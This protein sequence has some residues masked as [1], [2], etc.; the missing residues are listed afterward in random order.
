MRPVI[1]PGFRVFRRNPHQLQFGTS[2]DD[3]VVVGDRP[4]LVALLRLLD[5]TRDLATVACLAHDRIDALADDPESLLA[6]LAHEGIVVDGSSND[7]VEPALEAEARSLVAQRLAPAEITDRFVRRSQSCVEVRADPPVEPIVTAMTDCL[8]ESG[9]R[10]TRVADTLATVTLVVGSGPSDRAIFTRLRRDNMPHLVV[11][12]DGPRVVIGPF[13]YPGLTPCTQCLD[14]WRHGWDP[15]W[16]AVTPQLDAPLADA[17]GD[18]GHSTAAPTRFA[19]AAVVTHE[20]T[21]FCDE[22][23][24]Q[25]SARTITIGPDLH[26]RAERATA[27]H[28][29]C[30]CRAGRAPV[31]GLADPTQ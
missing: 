11:V 30:Q 17:C 8:R 6:A 16:A 4:G 31:A 5:G 19:A 21:A 26:E 18:D 20:L 23:T 28:P 27:F 29:H 25:T 12:A 9:I 2:G 13:V 15:S 24:P 7:V 1:R 10:T 3:C 14:L 22:V